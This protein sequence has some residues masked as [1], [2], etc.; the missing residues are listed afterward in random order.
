ME[1]LAPLCLGWR[2]TVRG[3]ITDISSRLFLYPGGI[4]ADSSLTVFKV[5]MYLRILVMPGTLCNFKRWWLIRG[6]WNVQ[7]SRSSRAC[8]RQWATGQHTEKGFWGSAGKGPAAWSSQKSK[9]TSHC[10][11][12]ARRVPKCVG[13]AQLCQ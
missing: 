9:I 5:S 8:G 6:T 10:H 4:G 11:A 3:M 2:G 13:G 12:K 1:K 7:V